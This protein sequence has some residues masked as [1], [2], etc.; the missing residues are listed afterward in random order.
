MNEFYV[1]N[2]TVRCR[3]LDSE[4]V[5]HGFSTRNGGVSVLP[6]TKSLNLC[7]GRGD[8]DGTVDK[9]RRL[10]ASYAGFDPAAL[11]TVNQ[12]HSANVVYAD[13]KTAVYDGADALVTDKPGV[14]LGVKT[15]DCQPV[16]FLDGKNGIVA[17]CHA[18]WRGTVNGIAAN[19]ADAMVRLGADRKTTVAVLGPCIGKCCFEVKDDFTKSVREADPELLRFVSDGHADIRAMNEYVLIRA[20]ILKENIY[21]CPDCTCCAKDKYYSH[22]RQKGLRGTMLNVIGLRGYLDGGIR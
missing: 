8:S 19:T 17:A 11:V 10:F 18:G 7:R 9:N 14:I 3:A 13:G 16:L 20:G 2:N 12:I 21:V 4:N 6:Y 15:A 1:K 22:R 5:I